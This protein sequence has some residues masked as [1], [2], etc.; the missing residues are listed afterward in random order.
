MLGGRRVNFGGRV[1]GGHC[2]GAGWWGRCTWLEAWG[3]PLTSLCLEQHI[4]GV[5]CSCSLAGVAW[6]SAF[7]SNSGLTAATLPRTTLWVVRVCQTLTQDQVSAASSR[8]L[9]PSSLSHTLWASEVPGFPTA[10]PRTACE[11]H[12]NCYYLFFPQNLTRVTIPKH[13]P[14]IE[15]YYIHCFPFYLFIWHFYRLQKKQL[16]LSR[17]ICTTSTPAIY[18]LRAYL[19][20]LA[21]SSSECHNLGLSQRWLSF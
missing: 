10:E 2:W 13:F 16:N 9:T 5:G 20:T 14:K 12:L 1:F 15:S 11:A 8:R 19:P 3:C 4:F 6:E 7:L 18:C 17:V 21:K